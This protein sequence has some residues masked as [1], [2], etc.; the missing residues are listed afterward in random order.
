MTPPL[1][2]QAN[3]VAK[4]LSSQDEASFERPM[5]AATQEDQTVVYF[6]KSTTLEGGPFQL[7]EVTEHKT[8]KGTKGFHYKCLWASQE[9][10]WEP[11]ANIKPTADKLLNLYW[12]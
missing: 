12:R 10:T 7:K 1:G 5:P 11:E 2:G 8:V 9:P 3:I 4:C 6:A